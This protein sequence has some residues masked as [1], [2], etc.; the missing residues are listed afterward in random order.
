MDFC[1]SI[2]VGSAFSTGLSGVTLACLFLPFVSS[3]I[4][5]NGDCSADFCAV[6]A[7]FAPTGLLGVTGVSGVGPASDI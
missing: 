3:S 7:L 5:S 6:P 2:I 1:S 4:G